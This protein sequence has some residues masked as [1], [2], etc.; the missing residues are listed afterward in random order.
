MHTASLHRQ[1]LH[2]AVGLP[3]ALLPCLAQ[4][5]TSREICALI[6]AAIANSYAR[7]TPSIRYA[8]KRQLPANS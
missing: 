6:I 1:N 8:P 2:S 5:L 7:R 4:R 3:T